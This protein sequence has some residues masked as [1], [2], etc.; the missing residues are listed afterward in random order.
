MLIDFFGQS[1]SLPLD[2]FSSVIF[3]AHDTNV[4]SN[5]QSYM[6]SNNFNRAE[7]AA[8]GTVDAPY[9][10]YDLNMLRKIKCGDDF[11]SKDPLIF[12]SRI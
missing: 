1:S 7:N 5:L 3:K 8:F 6:A 11:S 4:L 9:I 12:K 10:S 2:F